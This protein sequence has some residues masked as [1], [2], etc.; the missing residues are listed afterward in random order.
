MSVPYRDPSWVRDLVVAAAPGL[1]V[2]RTMIGRAAE[3]RLAGDW[4]GA[5]A[6]ARMDV[7][8]DPGR[9][10]REHG[11]ELADAL[12]DD[13]HHLVPDLVRWHFPRSA[14]PGRAELSPSSAVVLSRPG[15]G[16]GPR[17]VVLAPRSGHMAPQRLALDLLDPAALADLDRSPVQRYYDEG[18]VLSWEEERYLWDDRYVHEARERW[19][20]S[21]ERA[22]FLE[23]DGTPR[24]RGLLPRADPGPG[25]DP[26]VRSEWVVTLRQTG[27]N[28]GAAA[29]AAA[30]GVPGWLPRDLV[31]V[32]RGGSPD[33]L[34]PAVRAALA[35]ARTGD[36]PVGPPPWEPPPPVW[37]DCGG[38]GH[39]VT[40]R[41]GRL[42]GPHTEREHEREEA[43]R[44]FGGRRRGCFEVSDAWRTAR[45]RLPRELRAHRTELFERV[46]H[47]DT[48][49]VLRYLAAGG[50]PQVRNDEGETLLHRLS[51]V[52]HAVL[53]PRL[54]AAGLDVDAEARPGITPLYNA[55]RYDGDA[56][57]VRALVAAGA[58]T[59]GLGTPARGRLS[60]ASVV[61][62][63]VKAGRYTDPGPWTELLRDL[64][65]AANGAP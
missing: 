41:D 46:R 11:A 12:L 48:D 4:R 43:L 29:A 45:G 25:A 1:A 62:R 34:H 32:L 36:G 56:A 9:A 60:L 39:L 64:E 38:V 42:R 22:P 50:D 8:L 27:R 3:R 63:G 24:A 17:L 13:L 51:L 20:G 30:A 54:L 23:P 40:L 5:C 14:F 33:H 49:A 7:R 10:S 65:Q 57:L 58:R 37:V 28:S 26:A 21:A 44:A 55:A 53:L 2:P 19:G 15:G 47:G 35:P 31:T 18:G 59:D 16:P 6:A 61:D 52:D